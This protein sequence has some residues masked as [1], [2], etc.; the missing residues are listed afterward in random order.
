MTC[1]S[2]VKS[3]FFCEMGKYAFLDYPVR[4]FR[5]LIDALPTWKSART[6]EKRGEDVVF[7]TFFKGHVIWICITPRVSFG[8]TK[9]LLAEVGVEDERWGVWLAVL[10]GFSC[11]M[12][13]K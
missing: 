2:D 4:P 5:Q 12:S 10:D 3:V 1:Q 8:D 6:V 11:M 7:V 9:V 13:P